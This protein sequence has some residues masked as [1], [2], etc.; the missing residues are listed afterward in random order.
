MPHPFAFCAKGWAAGT[1]AI[2]GGWP[3]VV[4]ANPR[5]KRLPQLSWGSKAGH[6]GPRSHVHSSQPRPGHLCYTDGMPTRLHRYYRAGCSHF[7]TTSCYQRLPLLGSA[8]DRDLF[9]H[10]LEQVR[11]RYHFVLVGYVVMPEHVHLLIRGRSGRIRRGS[12]RRSSRAARRRLTHLRNAA[13]PQQL[14]LWT[15]PVER[16]RIWQPRFCDFVVFSDPQARG[17]VAVPAPQSGKARLGARARTVGLEQLPALRVC[18]GRT[19][20]GERAA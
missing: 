3:S 14:S 8:Q 5:R 19:G 20:P 9:V 1:S 2:K 6:H 12:C 11:R 16:G 15:G 10:V 7:V 4:L 18:R 13:T 17:E